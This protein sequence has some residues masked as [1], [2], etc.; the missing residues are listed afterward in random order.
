MPQQLKKRRTLPILLV[1]SPFSAQK[2]GQ[3]RRLGREPSRIALLQPNPAIY[4]HSLPPARPD[5][6]SLGGFAREQKR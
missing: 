1:F 4:G 5:H 3:S 2:F 6:T